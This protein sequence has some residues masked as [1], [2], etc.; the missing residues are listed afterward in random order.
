MGSGSAS[1]GGGGGGYGDSD[2]A[3]L[4]EAIQSLCQSTNP[5]GKIEALGVLGKRVKRV[6][7]V[8]AHTVM[9]WII[10]V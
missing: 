10:G 6:Q 7:K 9:P 2:V 8:T 3:K 5:L 4:K 1:G